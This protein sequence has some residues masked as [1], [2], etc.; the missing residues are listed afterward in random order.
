MRWGG[1]EGR[2]GEERGEEREERRGPMAKTGSKRLPWP[3]QCLYS[4]HSMINSVGKYKK[5][6]RYG[7]NF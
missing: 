5:T 2:G 4:I 7:K 3:W 1:G 6:T